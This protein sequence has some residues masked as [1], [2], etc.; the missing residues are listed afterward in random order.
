MMSYDVRRWN[1]F[2]DVKTSPIQTTSKYPK[3]KYRNHPWVS[4]TQDTFYNTLE[5]SMHS[6]KEKHQSSG[7]IDFDA[8]LHEQPRN[9]IIP[10]SSPATSKFNSPK[11]V[12]QTP[13]P[14]RCPLDFLY[15]YFTSKH[16]N[17]VKP[18]TV[19]EKIVQSL[20]EQRE[21]GETNI[22]LNLQEN[23]VS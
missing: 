23:K 8:A 13:S 4:Y 18:E 21:N 14:R 9:K 20:R 12:R 11:R 15:K 7:S 5:S 17:A 19:V 2:Q 22:S 1:E 3:K 10:K 16:R 6:T